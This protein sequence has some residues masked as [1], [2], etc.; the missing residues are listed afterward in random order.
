MLSEE[1]GGCY[2][3][4]ELQVWGWDGRCA[5]GVVEPLRNGAPAPS[6]GEMLALRVLLKNEKAPRVPGAPF[7]E[8]GY[9]LLPKTCRNNAVVWAAGFFRILLSSSAIT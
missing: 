8:S 9:C 5:A 1:S 2:E 7:C 3:G 4:E 6:A